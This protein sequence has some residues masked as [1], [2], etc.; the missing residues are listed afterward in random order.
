MRALV[1]L[2]VFVAVGF[3]VGL[4]FGLVT[5]EP[6]LLARHVGGESRSVSL[7]ERIEG[8]PGPAGDAAGSPADRRVGSTPKGYDTVATQTRPL[9]GSAERTRTRDLPEVAS[10]GRAMPAVNAAASAGPPAGE[11]AAGQERPVASQRAVP[12]SAR[13][14]DATARVEPAAAW[15]IQVGAFSENGAARR[16]ADSLRGSYPVEVLPASR[17]GGRWRVRVQPIESESRARAMAE[18]IKLEERLPT[19]V[20]PMEGRSG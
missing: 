6:E 17:E 9:T 2:I 12:P 4:V 20:T 3:G 19:W 1:R 18:R 5:E 13:S 11:R 7:Q 10:P 16:L 15:A 14:A 8:E